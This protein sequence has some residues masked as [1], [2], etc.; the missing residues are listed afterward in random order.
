MQ[1]V[2]IDYKREQNIDISSSIIVNNKVDMN[3]EGV[4]RE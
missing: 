3:S 1:F 2:I 4:G